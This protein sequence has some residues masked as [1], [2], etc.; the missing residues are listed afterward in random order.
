MAPAD[1]IISFLAVTVVEGPEKKFHMVYFD[2]FLVKLPFADCAILTALN[3]TLPPVVPLD[4]ICV[5]VV[6]IRRCRLL[7]FMANASKYA[8]A[9]ELLSNVL[10]VD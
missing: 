1:R 6:L 8:V 9:E 5:A 4:M 10:I 3:D 7:R 2:K